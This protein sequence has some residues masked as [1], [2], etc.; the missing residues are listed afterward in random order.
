MNDETTS[1]YKSLFFEKLLIQDDEIPNFNKW[2][3]D[4]G[5]SDFVYEDNDEIIN[6]NNDNPSSEVSGYIIGITRVF[7]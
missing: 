2:Q 6:Y 7:S 4:S 5:L 1:L 3:H